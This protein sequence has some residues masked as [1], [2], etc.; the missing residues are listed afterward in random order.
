MF[1]SLFY[2]FFRGQKFKLQSRNCHEHFLFS[3]KCCAMTGSDIKAFV[4]IEKE[5]EK[6][7]KYFIYLLLSKTRKQQHQKHE[8]A[9]TT[10][11][12]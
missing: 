6:D 7:S 3:V 12:Q 11:A 2:F 1:V 4:E 5:K 10:L 8:G 9:I